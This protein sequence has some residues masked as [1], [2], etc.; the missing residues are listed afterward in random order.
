MLRK[1]EGS[2]KRGRARKRWINS[3]KEATGMSLQELSRA[4]EDT[5]WWTSLIHKVT[6]KLAPTQ[7]HVKHTNLW[8]TVEGS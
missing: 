8:W 6:K 2:R 7:G 3:L 1:M 4:V 5:T